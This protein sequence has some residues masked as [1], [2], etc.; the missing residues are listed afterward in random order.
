[1]YV[2]TAQIRYLKKGPVSVNIPV[3]KKSFLPRRAI[4]SVVERFLHTEEVAGSIPASPTISLNKIHPAASR[5]I[6]ELL[7]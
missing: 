6:D 5:I 3:V 2:Q 1:M 7:L 4:S